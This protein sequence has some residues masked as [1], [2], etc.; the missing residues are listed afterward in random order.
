[1]SKRE[2]YRSCMSQHMG[3][4]RLKGLSTED[5]KIEFCTIAKECSK[6]IPY[7]EAK[8][9]CAEAAANP[10]PPRTKRAKK[11]CTLK[12]LD[13]ITTCVVENIDVGS[14]TPENM[15]KV[16]G[17]ALRKCSGGPVAKQRITSAKQAMATLDPEQLKVLETI[18]K[19][20]AQSEGRKW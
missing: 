20:T 14:L 8:R 13:A 2:E 9:L 1:M 17:D 15:T 18:G 3:G 19:L 16:F 7:D 6:D 11:I 4:G 12:D 10:K 5:R